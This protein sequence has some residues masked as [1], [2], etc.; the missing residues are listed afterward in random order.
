MTLT[1]GLIKASLPSYFPDRHGVFE[2]CETW[3]E[4]LAGSLGA[5][6]VVAD[7]IP[8]NGVEA[9]A[10]V[11]DVQAQGADFLMLLHG[12]FSMGDVAR[13][14]ALRAAA[15]GRLGDA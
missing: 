2:A 14:V 15:Y 7:A 9:R 4:D 13:E 12:G 11:A 3:L 5:R 10:A 8:M 6:V 1:I